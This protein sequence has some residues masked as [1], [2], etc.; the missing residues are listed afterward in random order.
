MDLVTLPQP[1]F[2]F[3]GALVL[4]C[5]VALGVIVGRNWKRRPV[6]KDPQPPELLQSRVALLEQELD[7]TRAELSRFVET[8]EFMREL[9]PPRD[10]ATAA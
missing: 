5:G 9:R 4:A 2:V 8:R 10:R 6:V 3:Y 7:L 1:L